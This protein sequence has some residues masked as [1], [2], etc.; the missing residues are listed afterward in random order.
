M[1]TL[2]TEIVDVERHI[3]VH[4]FHVSSNFGYVLLN[5]GENI[6]LQQWSQDD[7]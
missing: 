4:I 5:N 1:G 7:V 6:V 2:T 3:S